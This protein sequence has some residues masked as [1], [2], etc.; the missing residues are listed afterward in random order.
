M[1][2][3]NPY[4]RRTAD[5]DLADVVLTALAQL[6]GW[7]VL[8]VFAGVWWALLFPMI[9]IP[10][11]ATV[12]AVLTLG[13]PAGLLTAALGLAAHG[14]WIAL[15]PDSF[16][17]FVTVRARVRFL[18]WYRY[19]R[20]WT[21]LMTACKLTDHHPDTGTPCAPR[22]R[23]VVIGEHIDR[24]RVA[25]LPGQSPEDYHLRTERLAH[26]FG[27]HDC[28][29]L[30]AGPAAVELVFRHGDPLAE[31]VTAKHPRTLPRHLPGK[32]AA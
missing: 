8:T 27:A 15:S 24:V 21:R 23:T 32:D 11:A 18:R 25:M 12:A 3:H 28:R 31:P 22:L 29:A 5:P 30:D 4:T 20:R 7:L 6:L 17:R 19:R 26:A 14:T 9:S 1:N 10:I 16:R 2:P 13:W